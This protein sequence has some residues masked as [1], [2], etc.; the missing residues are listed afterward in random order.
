MKKNNNS[1]KF[2]SIPEDFIFFSEKI[3]INK[4]ELS[5]AINVSIQSGYAFT[6]KSYD[7]ENRKFE[8]NVV[9]DLD[10]WIRDREKNL[11]DELKSFYGELNND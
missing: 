4:L 6:P 2:L 1:T 10:E 5:K 3:S 8:D 9:N 11:K 7:K